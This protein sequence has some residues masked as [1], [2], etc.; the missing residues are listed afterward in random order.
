VSPAWR[1]TA[2]LYA[3][4]ALGS[5]LGGAARWLA[6]EAIHL[7]AGSGFPWATLFVNVTGSFLIGVYAALAGPDGRLLASPRQRQFVMTGLCG[8]YT[9]FS[10][11][12]LETVRLIEA[13]R[14]ALA[15]VNVTASVVLWLGSVWAGWAV[16]TRINRLRR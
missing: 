4:V 8:G 14:H 10:I 13:G 5:A 6:G 12:S 16:A 2:Q 3:A 11:F 15:G 7:W 1:E 9:T